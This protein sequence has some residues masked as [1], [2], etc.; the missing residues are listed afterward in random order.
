MMRDERGLTLAEILVAIAII[1]LGLIGLAVVIPISSYG[2]QE[3]SQLS[4]A[5]FLAEQRIE[6][7]RNAGWTGTPAN[8]CLGLSPGGAGAPAV[9]PGATCDKPMTDATAALGPPPTTFADEAAVKSAS[10]AT[11]FPGYA[12]TTRII[13]CT[14]GG[15][16]CMGVSSPSLRLVRVSVSFTPL[17]GAGVGTAPKTVTVEWLVARRD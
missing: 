4:T 9:Q 12:R 3:G 17:T 15:A 13:D 11:G 14:A 6:Q 5:A 1:G 16:Q 10:N 8:D 2:V 7:V